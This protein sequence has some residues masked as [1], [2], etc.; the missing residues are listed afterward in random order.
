MDPAANP[1]RVRGLAAPDKTVRPVAST[2]APSGGVRITGPAVTPHPMALTAGPGQPV[3][4]AR[5]AGG[6]SCTRA[7]AAGWFGSPTRWRDDVEPHG[8]GEVGA[9][10][11][12]RLQPRAGAVRQ[13]AAGCQRV[14]SDRSVHREAVPSASASAGAT[15]SRSRVRGGRWSGKRRRSA[16]AGTPTGATAARSGVEPVV[17]DQEHPAGVEISVDAVSRGDSSGFGCPWGV[18]GLCA[19]EH[20]EA[21]PP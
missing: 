1:R 14:E 4:A 8:H 6:L 9:D 11:S 21:V 7:C 20:P 12:V 10:R 13:G 16:A 5:G 3:R 19:R 17:P 2:S 15:M 18:R